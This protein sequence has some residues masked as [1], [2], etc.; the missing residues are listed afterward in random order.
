MDGLRW[1][2]G[3]PIDDVNAA[4]A[5][6]E[7]IPKGTALSTGGGGQPQALAIRGRLH[8]VENAVPI[9]RQASGGACPEEG[10]EAGLIAAQ[11]DAGSRSEEPPQVGEGSSLQQGMEN[12]PVGSIPTQNE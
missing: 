9:R 7:K 8:K 12:A 11:L 6:G 10:R 2:G 5:Q 4:P 3:V 1:M